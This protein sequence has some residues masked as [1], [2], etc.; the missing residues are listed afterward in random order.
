M[1]ESQKKKMREA[2]VSTVKYLVWVA[3]MVTTVLMVFYTSQAAQDEKI[4]KT[5]TEVEAIKA[6]Q[7]ETKLA[8][9]KQRDD[10][11]RTRE[12]MVK[13]SQA[14]LDMY[15]EQRTLSETQKSISEKVDG[16]KEIL[17]RIESR[18]NP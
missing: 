6:V 2:A 18:D 10:L 3:A 13:I 5:S 11:G 1:T 16:L 12:Q 17:I 8:V 7:Q 15:R 4:T 14:Q 9:E